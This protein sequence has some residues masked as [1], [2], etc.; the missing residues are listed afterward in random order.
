[1]GHM[2]LYVVSSLVQFILTYLPL[3]FLIRFCPLVWVS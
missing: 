1:M 2:G 3:S